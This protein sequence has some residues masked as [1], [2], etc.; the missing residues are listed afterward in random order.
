MA[1]RELG[2][3]VLG[4]IMVVAGAGFV[5]AGLVVG[6]WRGADGVTGPFLYA[7]ARLLAGGGLFIYFGRRLVR[8][9]PRRPSRGVSR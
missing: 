6:V 1:E 3:A 4:W 7:V 2:R 9:C 8:R 5:V